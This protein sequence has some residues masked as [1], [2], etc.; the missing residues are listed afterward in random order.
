MDATPLEKIY[1]VLSGEVTVT[2]QDESV[3][4]QPRDSCV[5]P[6]N[7]ARSVTNNGD[8]PATMLV[9]MPYVKG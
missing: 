7:E 3:I 2:T 8:G 1:V 9:I 6:P 4:L 5:I